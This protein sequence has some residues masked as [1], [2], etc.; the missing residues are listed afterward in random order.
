MC[1]PT[2]DFRGLKPKLCRSAHGDW[3]V[4]L[5][6]EPSHPPPNAHLQPTAVLTGMTEFYIST[7]TIT[8]ATGR[9]VCAGASSS[10]LTRGGST[11]TLD[12][13]LG[14]AGA[15]KSGCSCRAFGWHE[16][17]H[18]WIR[19]HQ[20][21]FKYRV[22]TDTA[23]LVWFSVASYYSQLS[24]TCVVNLVLLYLLFVQ[25][26]QQKIK[27]IIIIIIKQKQE[28]LIDHLNNGCLDGLLRQMATHMSAT[29]CM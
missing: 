27:I 6:S 26:K 29:R 15:Q 22:R 5:D 7:K 28:N 12:G 25:Q 14:S 9:S 10:L 19:I 2:A 16:R 11:R 18:S 3:W 4:S 17:I 13:N 8:G 1:N 23:C 21:G 20:K 24:L